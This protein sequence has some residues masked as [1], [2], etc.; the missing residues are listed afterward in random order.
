MD[1]IR[2][3]MQSLKG[4]TDGLYAIIQGFEDSTKESN[5]LADQVQHFHYWPATSKTLTFVDRLTLTSVTLERKYTALKLSLMKLMT[6]CKKLM[7]LWRR[8]TNN[9][10]KLSLMLPLS[11]VES[12]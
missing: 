3:K 9:S 8:R 5:R 11:P 4:E 10:R 6:N 7:S 12:C 1:A 2:K